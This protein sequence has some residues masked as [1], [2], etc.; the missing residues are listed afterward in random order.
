M[1]AVIE[2]SSYFLSD[3]VPSWAA[4]KRQKSVRTKGVLFRYLLTPV[5]DPVAT[6]IA[7]K[8]A[9]NSKQ[10]NLVDNNISC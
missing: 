2:P 5:L 7:A 3:P 4:T 8:A 9:V 6:G 10:A 1:N